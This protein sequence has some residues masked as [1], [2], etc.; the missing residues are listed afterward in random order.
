MA[1][2]NKYDLGGYEAVTRAL[3]DLL[4]SFPALDGDEFLFAEIDA[5][6]GKAFIPISGAKILRETRDVTDHVTQQCAYPFMVIYKAAGLSEN[7][8]ANVKEWLDTLARWLAK[9][10]V[11][12][13]GSD[14]KLDDYPPLTGNREMK[15]IECTSP[16]YLASVNTENV[17][18]W[19]IMLQ[20]IYNNEYDE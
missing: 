12:I 14:Y 18:Q 7:N 15:R 10:P 3:W 8:K 16:S 4:D 5:E 6:K 2:I 9:E 19:E 13:K 17:E 20:A 11:T 1:D